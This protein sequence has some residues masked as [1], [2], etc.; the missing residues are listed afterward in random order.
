M[1]NV[2]NLNKY[3]NKGKNNEIHVVS[4]TSFELPDTGLVT[5]LGESGSGKTTL[6]NV[7]GGLDKATGRIDYGDIK[8]KNYQMSKI[9]KY[10]RNNIYDKNE[11]LIE[12]Y[13]KKN[14][15]LTDMNSKL[16]LKNNNLELEISRYRS[17]KNNNMTLLAQNTT[18]I[19]YNSLQKFITN[20]KI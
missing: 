13:K 7:I 6:L 11:I 2:K 1:I 20:I 18:D 3:Y 4:D 14:Q 5:F 9:D 10:R 17:D 16:L 15:A 8:I 12:K 19:F